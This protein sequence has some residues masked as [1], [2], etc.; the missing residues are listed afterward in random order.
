MYA[1]DKSNF[2]SLQEIETAQVI[3][4]LT[5]HVLLFRQ[6]SFTITLLGAQQCQRSLDLRTME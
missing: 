6:E 1:E 2:A 5:V 4:W 3:F